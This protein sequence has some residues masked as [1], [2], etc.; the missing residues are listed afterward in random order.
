MDY[1]DIKPAEVVKILLED[2]GLEESTWAKVISNEG[3]YLYVTYLAPTSRVYK[4]ACVHEFDS[5]VSR[6]EFQSMMEHYPGVK[7]ITDVGW[8][9][10]GD[11]NAWVMGDEVDDS[12]TTSDVEDFS[13]SEEDEDE[14]LDFVVPDDPADFEPPPDAMEVDRQW[15]GWKPT[16]EGGRHFKNVVDQIESK[17]RGAYDD[18]R[19]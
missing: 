14:D 16:S 7:T 6:V 2:G 11:G 19:F 13:D 5:Q 15:E 18:V 9:R 10:V 1:G 4:G 3:E 8:R 17:V 12:V